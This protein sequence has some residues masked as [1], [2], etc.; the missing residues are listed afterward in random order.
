MEKLKTIPNG[1]H[2][3]QHDFSERAAGGC[4]IHYLPNFIT[5]FMHSAQ[6]TLSLFHGRA[7]SITFDLSIHNSVNK[8]LFSEAEK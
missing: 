8:T 3:T 7:T 5:V 6:Q 2:V 1:T 4:V